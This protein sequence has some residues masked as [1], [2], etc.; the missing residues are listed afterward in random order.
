MTTLRPPLSSIVR[1]AVP[2]TPLPL[3]S[4]S[5]AFTV[6][7]AAALVGRHSRAPAAARM[8][9]SCRTTLCSTCVP[10]LV[11]GGPCP[12]TLGCTSRTPPR[13]A[14]F[15]TMTGPRQPRRT[16]NAEPRTLLSPRFLLM[17]GGGCPGQALGVT[18]CSPSPW[19]GCPAWSG[20]W[21]LR[22]RQAAQRGRGATGGLGLQAGQPAPARGLPRGDVRVPCAG[23][24][25][26][27]GPGRRLRHGRADALLP[28]PVGRGR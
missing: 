7:S 2:L 5:L 20:G 16:A 27:G 3:T 24:P 25:R 19:P 17:K 18:R 14:T 21:G 28:G 10:P 6:V 12:Q 11:F 8:S 15:C 4:T 13:A 9:P 1:V 23:Q 26:L 22:R